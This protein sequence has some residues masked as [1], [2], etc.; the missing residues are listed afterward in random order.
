[1]SLKK[2]RYGT[3]YIALIVILAAILGVINLLSYRH[4]LRADLTENKQYTISASTKKVL[5]GLDDIVNIK[6]YFSKKLPPYLTTLTDQVT[7]L[8]DEYRTYAKG[9]LNIEFIDP[10]EDPTME[11]KLRFM[12]IPQVRLNVIERDQAQF[13]NVYLGMAILYGDNKEV[14]PAVTD[15]NILLLLSCNILIA[16]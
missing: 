15:T 4:F 13:T 3:N 1:M 16:D 12:G 5:A 2:V 8:L 14:I 7:D 10:A 6:V 9:N 11:Q